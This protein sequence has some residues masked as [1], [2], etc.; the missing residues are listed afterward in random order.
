MKDVEL[1][2]QLLLLVEEGPK[3]YSSEE[4]DEEFNK[5]EDGWQKKHGILE[6]FRQTIVEI[7][8]ILDSEEDLYRSRLQNQADF[9]SLFG[10]VLQQINSGEI[11]NSAVASSK[12]KSFF[13]VINAENQTGWTEDQKKYYEHTISASNRTTARKERCE[14]ISKLIR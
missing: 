2:A 10:G 4:L 5:R 6:K 3:G 9:Y 11:I 12:L 14:I 1:V 7:K 8:K 13:E